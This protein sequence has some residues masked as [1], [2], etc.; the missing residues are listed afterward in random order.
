MNCELSALETTST[1]EGLAQ[2]MDWPCTA[3]HCTTRL[4]LAYLH[5]SEDGE[6]HH[7]HAQTNR[8]DL[9][10]IDLH[11]TAAAYMKS[12]ENTQQEL[13]ANDYEVDEVA[14]CVEVCLTCFII[15]T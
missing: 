11:F 6:A 1:R 8:H 4:P 12:L 7:A 9:F 2:G 13:D 14:G 3:S 15:T 5:A 10:G